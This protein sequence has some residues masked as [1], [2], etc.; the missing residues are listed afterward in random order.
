MQTIAE[1]PEYERRASALLSSSARQA[2]IN[3]LAARPRAGVLL[4]GTGGI[5]K[6]RWASGKRG[7]SGG[8]RIGYYF[9][10]ESMPLFLLTVF[11]KNEQA[12]LSKSERNALAKLVNVLVKNYGVTDV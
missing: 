7:K 8:V 9:H 12:N 4:Q 1:L 5:R 11:G 2:I 10:D 3:H 6:L